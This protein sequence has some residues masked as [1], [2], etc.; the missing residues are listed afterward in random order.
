MATK[1]E[2]DVLVQSLREDAPGIR[3]GRSALLGVAVLAIAG[4]ALFWWQFY[5]L[6]YLWTSDS[7]RSIGILVIPAAAFLAARKLCREDLSLGGSWWGMALVALAFA[8]AVLGDYGGL[9]LVWGPRL[10]LN[11][12]AP[13]VLF[14]LYASGVVIL[15][16][17]TRAW[18]KAW[19]PLSLLLL[20]NPVPGAF[21][22]LVDLPLQ[23]LGAEAARSFAAL[24]GVPVQGAALNLM[25]YHGVLGMFIAPACNGL[26]GAVAMGMVAL[27]VGH[28]RGLRLTRHALFV[29]AAVLLA[30]LFN[31]L[32]LC[33]L[34]LYYALAHR[35]PL[36]GG[37]AVGADYLIG[38]TLFLLAAAFLF[39]PR[40][41]GRAS[42]A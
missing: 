35:F 37:Y 42:E 17:G 40:G 25:F 18:R 16:G 12:A 33:A 32:R 4:M 41:L 38:G 31:F 34:V 14:F 23:H 26:H 7:L 11:L 29:T 24:L 9:H 36:L 10:A 3:N 20:V 13:G 8:G 21:S 30:Y 22:T 1:L 2:S 5:S 28:L 39:W 6:F 15:L 19:F 27:V